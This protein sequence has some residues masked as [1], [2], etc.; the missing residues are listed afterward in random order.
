MSP[1][2]RV[3]YSPRVSV[4]TA[5][6]VYALLMRVLPYVL[7][8]AFGMEIERAREAYPWNF[9]PLYALAIFGGTVLDRRLALALPVAV[10]LAGDVLIAAI[11]GT[12]WGFYPDQP[13]T[14][15]AFLA[16]A[17]CGMPLR[18]RIG[19]LPVAAAGLGGSAA[20][21][22]VSNL[23]VWLAGGGLSRPRTPA[24]LLQCFIDALP[25]FTPTLASIAV[26]LPILYS[27]LVLARSTRSAMQVA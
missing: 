4:V 9:S 2:P 21:F 16:L 26:F 5:F 10:Y 14:Y 15:V 25:F 24:G 17:S 23:G 20:F 22:A 6:F 18:H 1:V 27:P 19:V 11:M 3:E 13:F 12:E 8:A 7:H